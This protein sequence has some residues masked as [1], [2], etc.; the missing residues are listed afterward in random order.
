[1]TG[2]LSTNLN[3][4]PY[5][6]D[7][8]SNSNYYSVLF[9]PSFPVQAREVNNLQSILTDQIGKMGDNIFVPGTIISGCNLNF[10]NKLPYVKLLDTYANGSALTVSDLIGKTAVSNS[11]LTAFIKL[12]K[13][14][15]QSTS[16]NL[17]TI[18][19]KYLNSATNTSIKVFQNDEV[20]SI[21]NSANVIIGQIVVANAVSS[22]SSNTSGLAYAV[23]VD[24]GVIYQKGM[25]IEVAKQT[26]I[27]NEYSNVPDGVSIGFSSLESIIT[28]Y[29]NPI[30]TD[31]AQGAPN[32]TAPGADRLYI[33]PQLVSVQTNTISSN[34][35]FSIA[36]FVLGAPSIVNQDTEYAVIGKKMAQISDD[37]NG[38]FIINPFNIR[39]LE[40]N[41]SNTV[42]NE[43]HI[44]LEIDPGIAYINGNRIQVI[45][46]LLSILAKGTNVGVA[47]N[48][49]LTTQFGRYVTVEDMGG[50]FDPTSLENIS[51]QSAN[52]YSVSKNIANGVSVNSITPP[53]TSIGSATVLGVKYVGGSPD[54]Q[55]GVYNVYLTNIQMANGYGFNQVASL[56][57]NNAGSL[58][59]AD[60][61][62][63]TSGTNSQLYAA[64]SG[65][66]L[67]S[68][69]QQA[70]DTLKNS[71]N[72]VDTQ[73]LWR[74]G[75]GVTFPTG[76][77]VTI[78]L[79]TYT[80]G[81]NQ[82]PYGVGAVSPSIA[83]DF[84]LVATTNSHSAN[85]AG[86]ISGTSGANTLTGAL[87]AFNTALYPGALITIANSTV[88][89]TKTVS[90]ITNSTSLVTTLNLN[91][92]WT[93]GNVYISYLT[94]EHVP[95]A[96]SGANVNIINSSAF[97]INL[98]QTLNSSFNANVFYNIQRT[99]AV[100]RKKDLQTQVWVKIDCSNNAGGVAGPWCLGVPDVFQI[101]NVYVGTTY[102]NTNPTSNNWVLNNGQTDTSYNLSYLQNHGMNLTTA[103]KLLVE[104]SCF[105]PDTSQ[106]IGFFSVDSYPI[107][108]TGLTANSIFTQDIPVY[109][110]AAAQEIFDLRNS[111][112]FR[113]YASNTIP[114]V[115]NYTSAIASTTILNPNTAF[116]LN[117]TNVLIPVPDGQF[118]TSIQYYMGRYDAV[119]L[120]NTGGVV[121]NRGIPSANPIPPGNVPNALTL[122]TIYVPPY[123]SITPDVVDVN[124][125]TNYPMTSISPNSLRRYT[126]ADIGV[127]DQ[128]ITQVEYYTSL[129]LL[130][131]S[132]QNL[133]LTNANGAN[134][135]QNG[136]IADPMQD[137][138]IANTTDPSFNIAID[139]IQSVVRPTFTQQLVNLKYDSNLSVGT[140][141]SNNNRLV[142]LDYNSVGPFI[143]QQF[144][145][146]QRNCSQDT[147]YTWNGT[148]ALSPDGDYF[149]DVTTNPTVTVNISSLSNW[150]NLANAWNTAYGTWNESNVAL[151]S[152]ATAISATTTTTTVSSGITVTAGSTVSQTL[153]NVVTSVALQPFCRANLIKFHAYGLKPNTQFWVFVDDVAV[154]Q[155]CVQTDANYNLTNT[156]NFISDA[157]G[158]FY[159]F[160]YL[161]AQTFNSGALSFQI[162][163]I[164][165]IVTE[166]NV[167]TSVASAT[168]YGTNLAY[169]QNNLTLQTTEPQFSITTVSSTA[170]SVS[171]TN[172]PQ[173]PSTPSTSVS[174]T[175]TGGSQIFYDGSAPG[176]SGQGAQFTGVAGGIE[177]TFDSATPYNSRDPLAQSFSIL[178]TTFPIQNLQAIY[179]TSV[180]LYFATKSSSGLGVTVELRTMDNGYPTVEIVPFSSVHLTPSQVN[181]SANSSVV[182]NV[183]FPAPVLLDI[184]S[185]Y[186]FVITP[187]GSNPDYDI[188]TAT[189]GGKDVLTGAPI[190]A[191]A[192]TGEMFL[193]S[194]GSTWTA[195]QNESVKF[196]L[197]LSNFTYQQGTAVFTNDDA[198]YLTIA[199]NF[200]TMAIGDP[201]YFANISNNIIGNTS[202]SKT[203]LN[204][205]NITLGNTSGL[206]SNSLLMVTS[207]ASAKA[208]VANVVSVTNSSVLVLSN[209]A[210]FT[211]NS[212]VTVYNITGNPTATVGMANSTYLIAANSSANATAYLSNNYSYIVCDDLSFGFSQTT[213]LKD[214]AY[215]TF[216]PKLSVSIPTITAIN[217]SLQGVSNSLNSFVTDGSLTP[218][219]IGTSTDFYDHARVVMSKSNEWAFKS[220][221]KSMVLAAN[222][223]TTNSLESP[224]LDMIK[225]GGVLIHN[226]VNAEQT[227]NTVWLSE[228]NNNGNSINRYISTTVTLASGMT[229]EDLTVFIGAFYPAN[230]NIYV[231]AKVQ[232]QYDSDPFSN[233]FWSPMVTTN[234]SRS[235]K[236]NTQ[237][238]NEYMYTLPTVAPSANV[239][240][241]YT[242]YLNPANNN[243]LTY[244]TPSGQS[245]T[246]YNLFAIKIVLLADASM[247]VP[248]GT[249][250]RAIAT[251]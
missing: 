102:A 206:T 47:S 131:Q 65:L 147:L 111:I 27:L 3:A 87:T 38:S 64:N 1:M 9:K 165:N 72:T 217:L 138:S 211:D 174:S 28:A 136:M 74:E 140:E 70:V 69:N 137:F 145:S 126:M 196:N 219:T 251:T 21:F 132:T 116:S 227:G 23:T 76:G 185:D 173:P 214:P 13:Q 12:G 84:D 197:Y 244:S 233:K 159:G 245:F 238:F 193:S 122:A 200:G 215:D 34:S 117:K 81:I 146:Q 127:L 234:T 82:L 202:V 133:L 32:Y 121:I 176:Q 73:F 99:G 170:S 104:V 85:I 50:I 17:N 77:S 60:I 89:E 213:A 210:P 198:E 163:D 149:P 39:T 67:Y 168:Y 36:D 98:N 187:D 190:Y 29:Q 61:V 226:Q 15:Y 201:L 156:T 14:G 223:V 241:A 144:A 178:P 78:T 143:S 123:P 52:A 148:I 240:N 109:F 128:R 57:A 239:P 247:N 58:G 135:F 88:T 103:D 155:Y 212:S 56:F 19:I 119:G 107:D 203:T 105:I 237:D 175:S 53:G 225:A 22:G 220:G 231:Y 43:N 2:K 16:P 243:V 180:D 59:F 182:T 246:G 242:A 83:T 48:Q 230:T 186:C 20:L 183:V 184:G 26:L 93:G 205:N 250:L 110:S 191:L 71:S 169:T 207:T 11:G 199:N 66:L 106:G 101:E 45:G 209:S 113:P 208:F 8:D 91:N 79:P 152:N 172:I 54:T 129:S 24:D 236:I 153:G 158:N 157:S 195:Y 167:I 42:Y 63:T 204:S 97:S 94:G 192:S 228:M 96:I 150:Q 162:M 171:V 222:L 108:D 4:A 114:L 31:N 90:S 134:R 115:N 46:K 164:S 160:F 100:P 125:R 139:P 188:W 221:N 7:F 249:D 166:T 118:E 18:F 181:T 232:N 248:M 218:L 112:D 10:D 44:K 62:Q 80:G 141:I 235:S 189:I 55:T 194:Q 177:F 51:L 224:A 35:F 92:S 161:P 37:T 154:S 216:M 5:W 25:F 179:A 49:I 75:A 229:S 6:N 130:E 40:L 86:S 30:L 41:T 124:M 95:L 33:S 120:S 151:S 68:L 142:T